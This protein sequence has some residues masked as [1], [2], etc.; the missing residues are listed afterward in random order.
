M[1]PSPSSPVSSEMDSGLLVDLVCRLSVRT[2]FVTDCVTNRLS[3]ESLYRGMQ[4][5]DA[6]HEKTFTNETFQ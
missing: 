3:P 5:S 6:V 1:T 4:R 2:A